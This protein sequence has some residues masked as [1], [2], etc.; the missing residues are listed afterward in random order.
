MLITSHSL[1]ETEKFAENFLNNIK[2]NSNQATVVGLHGDLGS[3]KTAFVKLCAKILGIKEEITSPTFVIMKRFKIHDSPWPIATQSAG[4]ARFK[5]LIHI[6]A[7]RLQKGEELEKLG[8]QDLV[9]DPK[10]LIMIEWPEQVSSAML[11]NLI[12]LNFKFVD[13]NTREIS[14]S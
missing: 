7:Y 12:K 2:P 1:S 10:N 5:N 9:S 6:D 11:N 8:W 4:Q 3:G 14:S 13:E